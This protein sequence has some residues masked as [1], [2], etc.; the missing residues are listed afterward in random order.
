M[1]EKFKISIHTPTHTVNALIYVVLRLTLRKINPCP[2]KQLCEE[3][4]R[5][6]SCVTFHS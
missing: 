4:F 1:K 2:G 6:V 3:T 5:N